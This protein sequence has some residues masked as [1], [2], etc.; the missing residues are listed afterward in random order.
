MVSLIYEAHTVDFCQ[1]LI[2]IYAR[3]KRYSTSGM[4]SFKFICIF[5][6]LTKRLLISCKHMKEIMEFQSCVLKA[7]FAAEYLS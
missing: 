4:I 7:I 5:K 2:G 1:D 6:S 3:L